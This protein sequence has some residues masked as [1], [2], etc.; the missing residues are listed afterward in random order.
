M[1][2]DEKD[3]TNWKAWYWGLM[4]FLAIQIA[5]YLFITKSFA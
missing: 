4:V 3:N 1:I 2:E 5:L